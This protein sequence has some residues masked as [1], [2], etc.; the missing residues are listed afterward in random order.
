[1]TEQE[2][3][4]Q[5]RKYVEA[6]NKTMVQ[7]WKERI[8]A[9][10]VYEDPRRKSRMGQD[11]LLD[12]LEFFP[13]DHDGKYM[14]F[15][16]KHQFLE[17]G[18]YQDFGVGAEKWRGNPGDYKAYRPGA[19]VLWNHKKERERRKWFSTKYYAS[20]MNIKDYMADNLGQQF[21]GIFSNIFER[22]EKYS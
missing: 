2:L 3:I 11:H 10:G 14:E 9:L 16:L 20:C 18:L 5:R 8:V 15:T 6:W 22:T 7:I 12:T 17:Y 19:A 21:V 1:M 13:V 4:E